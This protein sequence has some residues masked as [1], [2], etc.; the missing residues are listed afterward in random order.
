M[1]GFTADAMPSI[2]GKGT[3]GAQ[4][5]GGLIGGGAG[6]TGGSGMDG[7]ST[8]SRDRNVLRK[9]YGNYKLYTN[10]AAPIC[11]ISPGCSS[12]VG[13]AGGGA[14]ITPF[15]AALN[16]GDTAGT[17]NQSPSPKLPGVNQVNTIGASQIHANSGGVHNNGG[18]LYSGNSRYV[19]DG[20][21]YIRFKKLQA[22]N[23]NY[24]DS[25]FGGSNNGA[26]SFIM[27]VRS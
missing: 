19:Y 24:N 13:K 25:S 12:L 27:G 1:S 10:S 11:D 20:S 17:I 21:D 3:P 6:S 9:A 8:R 2:L 22:K 14:P 16:A 4:P 26:Y 15:R 23:R 7:A 18:A 5:R